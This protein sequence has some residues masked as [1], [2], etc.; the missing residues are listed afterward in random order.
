[1]NKSGNYA[2]EVAFTDAFHAV[3]GLSVTVK[4]DLVKL[5]NIQK[6]VAYTG[7]PDFRVQVDTKTLKPSDSTLELTTSVLPNIIFGAKMSPTKDKLPN[8]GLR[9]GSGP[10]FLA[11][12]SSSDLNVFKAHSVF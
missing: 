1:M 11:L 9:F 7:I 5:E 12:V 8:L 4:S 6:S 10:I 3:K 2:A